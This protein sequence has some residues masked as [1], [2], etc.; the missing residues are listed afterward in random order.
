M[1]PIGHENNGGPY[2]GLPIPGTQNF[3]SEGHEEDP[4]KSQQPDRTETMKAI[5]EYH[6][7][8][9]GQDH[10][11]ERK[12]GYQGAES[13]VQAQRR[14]QNSTEPLMKLSGPRDSGPGHPGSHHEENLKDPQPLAKPQYPMEPNPPTLGECQT[15]H[16]QGSGRNTGH[17]FTGGDLM[18]P[19]GTGYQTNLHLLHSSEALSSLTVTLLEQTLGVGGLTVIFNYVVAALA[20]A[21]R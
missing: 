6:A 18:G 7:R 3:P 13:D 16:Q 15:S 12:A 21:G 9:V 14:P 17:Q 5:D 4:R 20:S 10:G 1:S 19:A 8:Y 2:L 11:Y